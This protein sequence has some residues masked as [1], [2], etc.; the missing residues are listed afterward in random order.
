MLGHA[1]ASVFARSS[2][3]DTQSL[4]H[5]GE[6]RTARGAAVGTRERRIVKRAHVRTCV[7]ARAPR[8]VKVAA[9]ERLPVGQED[10]RVRGEGRAPRGAAVGAREWVPD[11]REDAGVR[12]AAAWVRRGRRKVHVCRER[13]V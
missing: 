2:D 12:G 3:L 11:G 9:R 8:C 7:R 4:F 13:V 6:E 10:V 5:G 1:E